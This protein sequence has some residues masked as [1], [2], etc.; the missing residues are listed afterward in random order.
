MKRFGEVN[1]GECKHF[2]AS[3]GRLGRCSYSELPMWVDSFP[4]LTHSN[5]VAND[6]PCFERRE[7]GK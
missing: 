6:C 4:P 5:E 1:C 2:E 7:A 3:C